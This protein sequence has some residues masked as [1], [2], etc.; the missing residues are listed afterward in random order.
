VFHLAGRSFVPESWQHPLQ[1]Y[2]TNVM[3]AANV[4][5]FCRSAGATLTLISSYVYGQPEHL[6]ITED[7]PVSPFNPYAH[8][9]ILGEQVAEFYARAFG[10]KTTIIRPFNLYGPGQDSR[11]LIP[12]LIAQALDPARAAVEFADG[13]PKR[14]YL[15][16]DDFV[17]LLIATIGHAGSVYNAGAG[18]SISVQDLAEAICRA[19]GVVKPCISRGEERPNEVF[20]VVADITRAA[21]VFGWSP[22]TS[23]S[24]GLS[25]TISSMSR[26][27]SAERQ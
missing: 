23:L 5:E 8:S 11:F 26:S 22:Q 20:D 2:Q 21:Q 12:L 9:K 14:D 10:V 25:A 19:A 27:G 6:P 15:Y 4:L 16:I 17:E 7:D 24:Q 18:S 3:G 1:F 13:R